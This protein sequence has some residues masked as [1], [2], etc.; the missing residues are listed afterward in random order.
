MANQNKIYVICAGGHASV[1]ADV[2]KSMNTSDI[3]S[4]QGFFDDTA[5][6][7]ELCG[8]PVIGKINEA[9]QYK[10]E[11]AKF[12]I[13][14][15]DNQARKRLSQE[16]AV[17]EYYTAT[18]ATAVLGTHTKIGSGTVIMPNTAINARTVIGNHVIIN[19]GAVVEHDCDIA[20]FVHISPRATLCG[21]VIVGEGSWICA[22]A[23]VVP[24]VNIGANVIVG[25]GATVI[26]DV[27]AGTTVV[28]T[29]A[30][31]ITLR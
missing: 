2:I 4:L 7:E 25:A 8:F 26:A 12:I 22:G 31:S 19:T 6:L 27:E 13:A 21:S 3:E 16:L 9:K 23:T 18:H 24:K 14:V 5:G 20:D 30:R 11:N 1:V 28:G 29:P 15:G 10:D 17:L